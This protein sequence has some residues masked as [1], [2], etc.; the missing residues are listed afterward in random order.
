[1]HAVE[2]VDVKKYYGKGERT[3][4]ALDGID[5]SIDRGEFVSIVGRSG[6]GKTTS[7]DCMGLLMRPTA[8]RVV[9]D[10]T[11]ADQL[12]D[13]QRAELRGRRIGFIFQEFNLLPSLSAMENIL[14]PLRYTGGDRE[15]G[16]TRAMNLLE[17]V[18]LSDRAG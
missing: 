12:N 13:G 10:G 5:L 17:E 2:L 18:G 9:L 11:D 6:S 16:R 1:M 3:V 14:L 7:L 15:K 4:R 8:G